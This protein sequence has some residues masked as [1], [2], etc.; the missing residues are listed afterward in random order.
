[1]IKRMLHSSRGIFVTC[2]VITNVLSGFITTFIWLNL[3]SYLPANQQPDSPLLPMRWRCPF[4]PWSAS[5]RQ[6]PCRR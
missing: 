4:L 6:N 2:V 5:A 1:M 3:S